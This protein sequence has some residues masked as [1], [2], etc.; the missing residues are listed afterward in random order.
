MTPRAR[1]EFRKKLRLHAVSHASAER[2][3]CVA[4]CVAGEIDHASFIIL[5]ATVWM[6]MDVWKRA[7]RQ[8]RAGSRDCKASTGNLRLEN[9]DES[10]DPI[11][12]P[13]LIQIG[14][15]MHCAIVMVDI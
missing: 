8:A 6:N 1:T 13:I 11:R 14:A 10:G 4:A 12:L 7:G 15:H 5:I 9:P 2:P 3:R